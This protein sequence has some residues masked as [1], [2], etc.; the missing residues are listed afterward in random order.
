MNI[1]WTFMVCIQ[2]MFNKS[3]QFNSSVQLMA[4][5]IPHFL[6]DIGSYIWFNN[7]LG[8]DYGHPEQKDC[9]EHAYFMCEIFQKLSFAPLN[10]PRKTMWTHLGIIWWCESCKGKEMLRV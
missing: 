1:K 2:Q 3:V 8:K 5:V 10:S 6:P 9:K 7:L 4:Q